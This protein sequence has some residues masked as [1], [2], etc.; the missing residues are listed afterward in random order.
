MRRG[1]VQFA[2]ADDVAIAYQ[3]VGDGAIDLVYMPPS[4]SNLDVHWEYPPHARYLERLA[5][6]SR[7]IIVDRRGWGVSDRVTPGSFPPLEVAADDLNAVL[8]AVGSPRAA[9]FA[10]AEAGWI[11]SIAAATYPD[12]YSALVLY[13]SAATWVRTEDT[14]WNNKPAEWQAQVTSWLD[15]GTEA[16]AAEWIEGNEPSLADDPAAARHLAKL[17]RGTIGPGGSQAGFVLHNTTDISAILPSIRVPTLVL[18]RP[19]N[20]TEFP[21]NGPHLASKIPN[22]RLVALPGPDYL[23]WAGEADA[24]LG[25]VEEFL[26]GVRHVPE[27]DRVLATVLFTDIVGSTQKA[28]EA[29]DARWKEV[30]A[31]H[32]ERAKVEIAK[33]RGTYVS[34]T[35][36]G[37]LATFDG[38]ARAVRCAEAIGEAVQDLGLEIRAG[39][40]TGEVELMS[41]GVHG[42]AVHIGARVAALAGPAEVLV[43]STVKD[44]VA[45]S[46]L[47]FEDR[48]EH[49]LKGVPDRWRLYRVVSGS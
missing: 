9:V 48:G 38:P 40:H 32:N 31:S 47:S 37:L 6:F 19:E 22:S 34:S 5:S 8:D 7:L 46:G 18:Y 29:G 27:S 23:P 24:L 30:L 28:A 41:D 16:F 25:E 20:T 35:G 21:E 39:C 2:W 49:E 33:M 11:A 15:V 43:S 45:G 26:T 42:I 17:M 14:P 10:G 36:D 1:D 13:Q 12:R 4:F 44:L 3:L